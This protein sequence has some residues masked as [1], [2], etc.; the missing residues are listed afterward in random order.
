MFTDEK[1]LR[2]AQ[3]LELLEEQLRRLAGRCDRLEEAVCGP[4]HQQLRRQ[5]ALEEQLAALWA[6]NGMEREAQP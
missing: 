1:R 5:Q 2:T 4:E 3:R 6:Y